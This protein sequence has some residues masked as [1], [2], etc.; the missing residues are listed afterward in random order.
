MPSEERIN[1]PANPKNYWQYR[2]HLTLEDLLSNHAFK[3]IVL[4]A[5]IAAGRL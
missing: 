4:D 2:M 3:K 1:D 5:V